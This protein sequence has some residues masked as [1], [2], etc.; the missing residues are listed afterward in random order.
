MCVNSK[1]NELFDQGATELSIF[2][3]EKK[4]FV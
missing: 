3:C 2:I 1:E 4:G